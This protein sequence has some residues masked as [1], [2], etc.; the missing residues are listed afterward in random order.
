MLWS[1]TVSPHGDRAVDAG[2]LSNLKQI[3]TGIAL[4]SADVDD[5][6]P[7]RD[8]WMDDL[9]PYVKSEALY[10]CPIVKEEKRQGY[11]YS[12]YSAM[13]A[14]VVSRIKH[15]GEVPLL[16]DS[17]NFSRN[18]SDLLTSFPSPGRHKGLNTI[19]FVDTHAKRVKTSS[20]EYL[21]SNER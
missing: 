6:L 18:A 3:S 5:R 14:R 21:N 1:Q 20:E 19:A 13:E 9:R 12:F 10:V 4:Y 17:V 7:L 16:Y 8:Q 2:C 11:G 15:P